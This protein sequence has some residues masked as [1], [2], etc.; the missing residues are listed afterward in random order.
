MTAPLAEVAMTETAA[1]PTATLPP[2]AALPIDIV[3]S[4][5][6]HLHNATAALLSE[7]QNRLSAAEKMIAAQEKRI[8][9]LEA[10]ASSDAL[11]GLLNRRG[12]ENFVAQTRARHQR[13]HHAPAGCLLLID[14]DRFKFINDTCGHAAGDACLK[15]VAEI[16]TNNLRVLDG[17]ARFGGD[18]FAVLLP[19]T[20][21]T[22][23]AARIEALREAIHHIDVEYHGQTLHFGASLGAADL[24]ADSSYSDI[25]CRA[26]R[27]LY[28]DKQRRHG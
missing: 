26:D 10:L 4:V 5:P 11:T 7:A 28:A 12:F 16:L 13:N 21:S 2:S 17:I 25:F 9:E 23:A 27:A 19:D 15:K 22:A 20:D 3:V 14:L 8:R 1:L 18:E 6:H 24:D